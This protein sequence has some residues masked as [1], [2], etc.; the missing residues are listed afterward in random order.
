MIEISD[1]PGRIQNFTPDSVSFNIVF[2]NPCPDA[3]FNTLDFGEAISP[4]V[5]SSTFTIS[6][7]AG[8]FKISLATP[9]LD[10]ESDGAT[11]P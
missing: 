6:D 11:N 10:I 8:E 9:T 7:G 2:E 4:G 1:N 3:I 5:Y